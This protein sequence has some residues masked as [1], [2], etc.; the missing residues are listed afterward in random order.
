MFAD[1]VRR[2]EDA[3]FAASRK[4][5][6]I[7]V[8][9]LLA[10]G[11]LATSAAGPRPEAPADAAAAGVRPDLRRGVPR[12]AQGT[13]FHVA[14]FNV[15]GYSHTARAAT[16]RAS[17]TASSGWSTPTGS[18]RP[19]RER[20]GL[21]GAP[22][23]AVREVQRDHRQALVPLPRRPAR[24]HRDAQL[25]R[26]ADPEVGAGRRRLHQHPLLLRRPGQDADR[27]AAA[28]GRPAG[29]STSRT[30]TTRR[31]P[32]ATPR[33]GATRPAARRSSSRTA[34]SRTGSRWSSPAT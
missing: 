15:L 9:G 10:W 20:G 23:A 17:R 6:L 3:R 28:T 30:S 27:Q 18:C 26:L 11:L 2:P 22:A 19:P 8:I 13:K 21:P 29:S 12:A 7:S 5:M 32:T 1:A 24:A 33:S 16:P 14:S 25:D 4:W 34:S 31:T